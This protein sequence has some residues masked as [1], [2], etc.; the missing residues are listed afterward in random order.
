MEPRIQYAKTSDGV[1]IAFTDSGSG[2]PVVALP[3]WFSHVARRYGSVTRR[4]QARMVAAGARH[5]TYDGRGRGSS[6][7]SVS[8]FS[9]DARVRDLGAVVDHIGLGSFDLIADTWETQEAIAHTAERPDRASHLI[10]VN[11][12]ADARGTEMQTLL[13]GLATLRSDEQ[14]HRPR[15][16]TLTRYATNVLELDETTVAAGSSLTP[17]QG[18]YKLTTCRNQH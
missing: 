4:V 7:R 9:L 11:P 6:D 5:V 16:R 15:F 14:F 3:G 10:L 17:C 18:A 12:V 13:G 1:N 8:D 2:F